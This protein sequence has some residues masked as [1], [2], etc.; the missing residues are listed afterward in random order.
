MTLTPFHH[1]FY[2]KEKKHTMSNDTSS[3]EKVTFLYILYHRLSTY[4]QATLPFGNP[5]SKRHH[6]KR[7]GLQGDHASI[8][9]LRNS[10]APLFYTLFGCFMLHDFLSVA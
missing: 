10:L 7:R 4:S 2:L 9:K 8:I 3:K 6:I 1:I 5:L